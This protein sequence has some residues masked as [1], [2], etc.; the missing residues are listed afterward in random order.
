MTSHYQLIS[1]AINYLSTHRGNHD[2]LNSLATYLNLS[3][4]HC[5]KLFQQWVGLSPK[6]FSQFLNRQ[7]AIQKLRQGESVLNAA[8]ESGLSGPGRLHD[9]ALHWDAMTPG[10][11][12]RHGEGLVIKYGFTD[13]PLGEILIANTKRGICHLAFVCEQRQDSINELIELW[14]NACTEYQPLAAEQYRSQ[15]FKSHPKLTLHIIGT[16]FQHKVWE[17][18]MKI[19]YQHLCSYQTIARLI[20]QPTAT[21]A[22]ASAVARNP[23][24]LLI[25]CHRVIRQSGD[26]GDYHWGSERKLALLATEQANGNQ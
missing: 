15:L 4:S 3:P 21:R 16:P 6:Q 22:V 14:P 12:K 26:F 25:P 11:I 13:T 8:L 19:P 7:S 20:E 1:K 17:A 9:L 2:D 23:I 10:Q 18:L 24:G 5:Q